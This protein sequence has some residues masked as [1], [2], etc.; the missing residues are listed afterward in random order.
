MISRA[1]ANLSV[2]LEYTIPLVKVGKTALYMK[3]SN[4]EEELQAAETAIKTLGCK[5][6]NRHEYI[7]KTK[8]ESL[9]RCLL[10]IIK[11]KKTPII[12]P[13]HNS[14]IKKKPL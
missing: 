3:G 7:L 11:T 1:V 8:S 12:Y 4:I 10:E 13:R 2:L 9:K 14:K 6:L 5:K